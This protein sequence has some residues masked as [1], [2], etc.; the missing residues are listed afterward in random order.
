M[1][2][3]VLRTAHRFL[4]EEEGPSATEYAV[5]LALIIVVAAAMI[6]QVG[7]GLSGVFTSV[8][9]AMVTGS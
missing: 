2:A 6:G 7:T 9:T 4:H 1:L 8:A 5:M 3:S